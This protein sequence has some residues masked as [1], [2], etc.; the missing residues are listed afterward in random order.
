MSGSNAKR[1]GFEIGASLACLLWMASP[2]GAQELFGLPLYPGARPMTSLDNMRVNGAPLQAA[3][4]L[5]R[6]DT[7]AILDFYREAVRQRKREL[8]EGQFSP[9]RRYVGFLDR[10]SSRV[11]LA[12]VYS[13][14]PQRLIIL[15]AMN[16][17]P[18]LSPDFDVPD[19][20][21][22]LDEAEGL[23]LSEDER[24]ADT[25]VTATF[26]IRDKNPEVVQAAI[27]ARASGQGWKP[28]EAP[29]YRGLGSAFRNGDKM[30][31][32][33]CELEKS[34][35]SRGIEYT[36]VHLIR[37]KADGATISPEE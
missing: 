26:L 21:P 12:T 2:V 36:R 4:F 20:L 24:G 35:R 29:Q 16:P 5:S 19:D 25:E 15:S 31:L 33:R 1:L 37:L 30:L 23:T 27:A 6:D 32:V 34:A 14:G 10:A 8:L 3:V 9:G 11:H 18:L 7:Q 17:A 28:E 13:M 22:V